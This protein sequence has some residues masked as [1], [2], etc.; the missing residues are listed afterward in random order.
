MPIFFQTL[1][2]ILLIYIIDL[3]YQKP[4]GLTSLSPSALLTFPYSIPVITVNILIFAY[5][6][7]DLVD[8]VHIFQFL[9]S[10]FHVPLFYS[11]CHNDKFSLL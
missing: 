10:V 6:T 5:H 11:L 1:V 3:F 7:A 2:Q 4:D 8:A 9:C